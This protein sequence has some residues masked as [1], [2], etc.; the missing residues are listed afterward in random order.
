MIPIVSTP[1]LSDLVLTMARSG[2][3]LMLYGAPG[4]G[5]TSLLQE[6]GRHTDLLA[7]ASTRAGRPWTNSRW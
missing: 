1:Q 7:W 5:K 4:I 6:M 2:L 3:A